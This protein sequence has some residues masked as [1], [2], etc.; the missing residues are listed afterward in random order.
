MSEKIPKHIDT[1]PNAPKGHDLE[2]FTPCDVSDI[3]NFIGM[4]SQVVSENKDKFKDGSVL[5]LGVGT[6]RNE[7][8]LL[9][10][11]FNVT[12]IDNGRH[13]IYRLEKLKDQVADM[14]NAGHLEVIR[15][16]FGNLARLDVGEH[17]NAIA[18]NSLRFIKVRKSLGA[19]AMMQ[20]LTKS[21]GLN[22]IEDLTDEGPLYTREV[23]K[24]QNWQSASEM[25]SHYENDDWDII[26]S[27]DPEYVPTKVRADDGKSLWH[28]SA[29]I[30]ARKR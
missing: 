22:V 10:N 28:Q 18:I 12:A 13:S 14:P 5:S 16:D 3:H 17:D 24:H 27:P 21:G 7:K 8:F 23:Q 25:R 1:T 29:K 4:P 6:G 20:Q 30:V 15:A 19:L 9:Q 2:L 11:G 26:S